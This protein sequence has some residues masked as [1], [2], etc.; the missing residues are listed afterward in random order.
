MGKCIKESND[1]AFGSNLIFLLQRLKNHSLYHEILLLQKFKG[2]GFKAKDQIVSSL[3][4]YN[5]KNNTSIW[6]LVTTINKLSPDDILE[7]NHLFA[8]D[9]LGN[10][11]QHDEAHSSKTMHFIHFLFETTSLLVRI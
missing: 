9:T 5:D 4:N 7:K 3:F 6:F 2:E 1:H 8:E 11:V 10:C